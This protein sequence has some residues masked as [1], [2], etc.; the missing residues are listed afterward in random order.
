MNI[1]ILDKAP[2]LCAQ[3]HCDKHVIKMIL[4]TAQMMCTVL[5]SQ[6][7]KTPY[8]PTHANHPCTLWLQESSGNWKWAL[9]MVEFLDNEYMYRYNKELSHASMTV[10]RSLEEPSFPKKN[11]T[12][13]AQAMPS[14]YQDPSDPI[15]AYRNYYYNDKKNICTWTKRGKPKWFSIL[16]ADS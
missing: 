7:F 16:E 8:R 4:E 11:R 13:F 10:I 12:K 14:C 6:G 9:K 15:T 5:S 1:F 2:K 3:Y